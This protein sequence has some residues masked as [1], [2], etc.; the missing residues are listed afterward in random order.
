[1]SQDIIPSGSESQHPVPRPT[2]QG[3]DLGEYQ[4]SDTTGV[5]KLLR[6]TEGYIVGRIGNEVLRLNTDAHLITVSPTGGGKGRG[7]VIPNLLDHPGSAIVVDIR[8]ETVE[9]TAD[10]RLLMGQNVVV[11]DPYDVTGGKWG[12][13][14][15]NPLAALDPQDMRFEAD[16][17]RIAKALMFDPDGRSSKEPIWDNS[18]RQMFAGFLT[19]LLCYTPLEHQNLISLA[20]LYLLSGE[21]R[22]SLVEDLK[23]RY[24]EDPDI[25]PVVRLLHSYLTDASEKTKIPDNAIVQGKTSLMWATE[26]TFAPILSHS[27]QSPQL[28]ISLSQKNTSRTALSGCA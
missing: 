13:D 24:A 21:E 12:K 3:F 16:I 26:R 5:E 22:A 2:P 20:N 17:G 8:G 10:A 15:F 6:T 18:T 11:L 27:K 4:D 7:C 9:S 23:K 1:M 19:Y 14:S 25:L 28:Y